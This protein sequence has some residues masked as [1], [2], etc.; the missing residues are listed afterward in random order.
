MFILFFS[1]R[2]ENNVYAPV[3]CKGCREIAGL[4]T[5]SFQIPA[6]SPALRGQICGKIP[7]KSP[8]SPDADNNVEQHLGV[9]MINLKYESGA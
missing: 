9:V 4:L 7:G 1:I 8:G 5:Y 3:I 2:N 6:K